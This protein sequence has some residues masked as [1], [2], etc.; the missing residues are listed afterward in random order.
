[1]DV[2]MGWPPSAQVGSA[3]GGHVYARQRMAAAG[4]ALRDD[5]QARGEHLALVREWSSPAAGLLDHFGYPD[6]G[7]RQEG[8]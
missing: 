1:M 8:R 5:E 4:I 6:P 2:D 7:G 3:L